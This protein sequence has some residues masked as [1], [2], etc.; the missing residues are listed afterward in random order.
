[1]QALTRNPLASPQVFGVNAG[2]SLC[3]VAGVVLFPSAQ[4]S[5]VVFA[6]LGAAIG[7]LIV[8]SFGSAGGMTP[9]KLALAGIAV[10]LFLSAFTHSIIILNESA[11]DV[12]FWMA[13]AISDSNWGDVQTIVPWALIGISISFAMSGS[14]SVL[15]LGDATAKGLGQ[16]ITIIRTAVSFLVLIL[17]GSSVAVA[18]PIGF[19]GLLVPHIARKLVGED[20]RFVLPFS[21]LL[22]AILL[23]YA[24][25]LA[26]FIAYPYESPVGIV[27]AMIGTP[28]FLY[29]ASKGRT[30]K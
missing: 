19:V 25:V 12:L 16:N 27:T 15:G 2:A 26:R 28:F 3:V 17:A 18:G 6:F 10:H 20:Y 5:V 7:G 23:V 9:V 30:L 1:M 13:G 14:V 24:D 21:A 22:G 11:D 29:L 8:Y 4:I